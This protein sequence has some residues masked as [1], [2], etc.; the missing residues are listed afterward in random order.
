MS[1][2]R[3]GTLISSQRVQFDSP[4]EVRARE[5]CLRYFVAGQGSLSLS[6]VGRRVPLTVLRSGKLVRIDVEIADASSYRET[7]NQQ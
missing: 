5:C 4:T 2:R 6:E 3:A 1:H 7:E